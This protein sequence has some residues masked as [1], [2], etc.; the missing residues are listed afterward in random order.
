M[1]NYNVKPYGFT[2][3]QTISKASTENQENFSVGD[4]IMVQY[5]GEFYPGVIKEKK[6]FKEC[7]NYY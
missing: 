5:E 4:Y 1:K 2:K 6:E 3:K 7:I